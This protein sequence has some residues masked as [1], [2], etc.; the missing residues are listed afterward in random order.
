MFKL[1]LSE[2]NKRVWNLRAVSERIVR[3][4]KPYIT[5]VVAYDV[6]R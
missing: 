6:T 2:K 5:A 4:D 1:V 3:R